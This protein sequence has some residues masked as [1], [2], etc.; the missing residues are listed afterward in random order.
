MAP[1]LCRIVLVGDAN[2]LPPV[3]AGDVFNDIIASGTC[4]VVRLAKNYRNSTGILDLSSRILENAFDTDDDGDDDD[5]DGSV[6]VMGLTGAEHAFE[7]AVGAVRHM[8]AQILVP[9]NE[10][11]KRLNRAVQFVRASSERAAH[12][13][14]DAPIG[15][16]GVGQKATMRATPSGATLT[17]GSPTPT[18]WLRTML[19]WSSESRSSGMR[20]DSSDPKPVVTP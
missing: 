20:T 9:R 5:G 6:L 10:T 19:S 18:A 15:P 14:V 8:G 12:V 16:F 17:A 2:Q 1:A 3:E 11:R 7:A 13:V 4:P